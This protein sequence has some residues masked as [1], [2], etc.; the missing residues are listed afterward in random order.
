MP[1]SDAFTDAPDDRPSG[2]ASQQRRFNQL[3][4][5]IDEARRTLSTWH[6]NIPVYSRVYAQLI[7]P[8]KE[9][10]HAAQREWVFALDDLMRQT[11]AWTRAERATLRE[12][13]CLTASALLD[14][15]TDDDP[16]LQAL[17][18]AHADIDYDTEQ[19]HSRLALKEL[20]EAMSGLD[21]GDG[22]EIT[23]DEEFFRRMRERLIER[24]LAWDSPDSAPQPRVKIRARLAGESLQEVY[25][26]V[27]YALSPENDGHGDAVA[28]AAREVVRQQA[29]EAFAA[30][31]L[32]TLLRLQTQSEHIDAQQ[33]PDVNLLRLKRYNALLADQLEELKNDVTHV[34][35]GFRLDFGLQAG[36]GMNPSTLLYSI[37]QDAKQLRQTL[38]VQRQ[39]LDML[40]DRSA[41]RA[42]LK[43]ERQRLVDAVRKGDEA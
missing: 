26:A 40:A 1:S 20:V 3:V 41:T 37:D 28:H 30:R 32:L 24:P 35:L 31:D 10:L 29:R 27:V 8:L 2:L 12:L 7:L 4:Q 34:E 17:F 15:S 18:D 16:E 22:E 11:T 25:A 13:V 21:L 14:Q 9:E 6:A 38:N 36:W 5:H 39:N 19:H 43:R 33:L 23:S 42:W